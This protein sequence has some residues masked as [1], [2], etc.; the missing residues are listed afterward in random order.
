MS[1]RVIV[2]RVD[3][4]DEKLAEV[5]AAIARELEAAEG[6]ERTYRRITS[7]ARETVDGCDHA[8]ISLVTRR[9]AIVT[10]ASTDDVP[11]RVDQIQYALGEGPCLDAVT[12]HTIN[13]SS[14]LRSDERW[15]R[16]GPRAVQEAQILSMLSFQL[17]VS[18]D[19][20]GG[21]NLYSRRLDAFDDHARAVGAILAAHAAIAMSAAQQ[22]LHL[23]EVQG[24]V[25]S[26]RRI[27]MALGILMGRGALT[28]DEAFA[29][30][31]RASMALNVKI[32]DLAEDVV[33]TGELPPH[34]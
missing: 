33:D 19:T 13:H 7:V 8:A 12:E 28:E 31:R 1:N 20:I 10:V 30:L 23:E 27:G 2:R 18:A 29:R 6:P 15:P 34:S 21:L 4:R 17:S 5:F 11:P 22:K 14:D 24:A 26:N 32:R 9:G 16:F 25:Q 3:V